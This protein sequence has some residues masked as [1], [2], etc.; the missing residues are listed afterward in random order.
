[1]PA[2]WEDD[3]YGAGGNREESSAGRP[4]FERKSAL[5]CR[6]ERGTDTRFAV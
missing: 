2:R 6:R 4:I 3:A 1:M 5:F